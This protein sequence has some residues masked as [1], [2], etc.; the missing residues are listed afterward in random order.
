MKNREKMEPIEAFKKFSKCKAYEDPTT[1]KIL[2]DRYKYE[3]FFVLQIKR[4]TLMF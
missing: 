2:Y 3:P 1:F 4:K